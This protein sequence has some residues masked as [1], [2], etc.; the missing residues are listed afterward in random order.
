MRLAPQFA[1]TVEDH[2]RVVDRESDDREQRGDDIKADLEV[3]DERP[4]EERRHVV[5]DRQAGDR[6]E[7]V[8][9]EGHD[10]RQT[11]GDVLEPQPDVEHDHPQAGQE[12]I[13]RRDLRVPG[14]LP[15]DR[16]GRKVDRRAG[17]IALHLPEDTRR[18]LGVH[19]G[20]E[21][22]GFV[23]LRA[24]HGAGGL[25]GKRHRPHSFSR[26]GGL[27]LLP[28]RGLID[29]RGEGE[30]RG[31]PGGFGG[32][33]FGG[34][35]RSDIRKRHLV[36]EEAVR[37]HRLERPLHLGDVTQRRV[38]L[39]PGLRF[40][41]DGHRTHCRVGERLDGLPD[42]GDVRS[43]PRLEG[44]LDARAAGEVD[45]EEA[46]PTLGRSGQ[47][48]EDEQR[49]T[50][51]RR[52]HPADELVVRHPEDPAHVE[53]ANPAVPLGE[54]EHHA[55]AEHG[56]EQVEEE[57]EDEGDGKALQLIGADEEQ[58][59]TGDDR[60]QVGVEDR[61]EG[62]LEAV[63]DRHPQGRAAVGLLTHAFVDEHV[64]IDRHADRE[65][66]PREAGEGERRLDRDH[67][68]DDEDDVEEHREI[69]H[70][71]GEAVVGEHE[72]EDDDRC[73][74][75]RPG[76]GADRVGTELRADPLFADRLAVEGGRQAAGIED[77]DERL[78]VALFEVAGDLPVRRDRAA[79]RRSGE[80]DAVEDDP[81][82]AGETV[83][84]IGEIAAGEDT[85][86][87]GA[88]RIEREVHARCE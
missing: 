40:S 77:A 22:P 9:N 81:Q 39:K 6:H 5:R 82:P 52:P 24:G 23:R 31:R 86:Q 43:L 65:H 85:E 64:G 63:A 11:E 57:A 17:Q 35:G 16:V 47:A 34:R 41:V 49:R 70:E 20:G 45:V 74:E 84:R 83:G 76:P 27:D 2:D 36:G 10:C 32:L 62:P 26:Q 25:D 87:A 19:A 50:E 61:R 8:V 53:L 29:L 42:V 18:R 21:R 4:T 33:S 12:G 13:N 58:D 28:Q 38:D 37:E 14:H 30:R 71:A 66:E 44:H 67:Q 1:E 75:H 56:R 78:D 72:G 80:E 15:T 68:G 69:G 3:V 88:G 55:G 46:L 59:N 73:Q 48:G 54:I 79:D 60:R 7:D 51:D